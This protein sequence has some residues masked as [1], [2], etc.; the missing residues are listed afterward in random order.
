MYNGC[1]Q[2]PPPFIDELTATASQTTFTLT[3]DAHGDV[4]MEIDGIGQSISIYGIGTPNTINYT[5]PSLTGGERVN[6]YYV[7]VL[8]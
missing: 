5:G 8:A 1:L 2:S 4:R 7:P 6:F 3:Y